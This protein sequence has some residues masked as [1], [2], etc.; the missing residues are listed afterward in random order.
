MC[1]SQIQTCFKYPTAFLSL[2][3]ELRLIYDYHVTVVSLP[4]TLELILTQF[5]LT[6]AGGGLRMVGWS[7]A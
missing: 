7:P 1:C 6:E 3:L 4:G 2:V 5:S